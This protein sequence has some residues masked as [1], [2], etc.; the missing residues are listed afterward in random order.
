GD[1]LV[2]QQF[3]EY[4]VQR[5]PSLYLLTASGERQPLAQGAEITFISWLEVN[6]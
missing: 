5:R 1:Y 4:P 6:E 3:S 2:V